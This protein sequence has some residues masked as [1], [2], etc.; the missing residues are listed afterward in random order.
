[1]GESGFLTSSLFEL[2]SESFSPEGS[3]GGSGMLGC[4]I[5]LPFE[6]LEDD[7]LGDLGLSTCGNFSDSLELP[8]DLWSDG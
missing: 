3:T 8:D 6:E 5:F 2:D 1:M 7:D 4:S